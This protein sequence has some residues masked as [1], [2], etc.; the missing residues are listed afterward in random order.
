MQLRRYFV[1]IATNISNRVF[2]TGVTNN[3]VRRMYEHINLTADGFTTR[4]H[5]SKLVYFEEY[6]SIREAIE[7][8][9]QIKAGSR[10]KKFD[11]IIAKNSEFK[12]LFD[13]IIVLIAS[14]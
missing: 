14:S 1:Y 3:L 2:Y 7:R 9:K 6:T 13:Q 8:E 11:L 12:N 4:Y 5:I 10:K